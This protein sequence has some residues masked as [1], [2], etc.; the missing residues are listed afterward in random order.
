MVEVVA[1]KRS[2]R[3]IS[4]CLFLV[5][6]GNRGDTLTAMRFPCNVYRPQYQAT[7]LKRMLLT[8]K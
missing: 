4:T 3:V 5:Y 2:L 1:V 8:N 6:C 7:D